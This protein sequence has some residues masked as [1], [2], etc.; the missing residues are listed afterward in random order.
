MADRSGLPRGWATLRTLLRRS[1]RKHMG[2]GDGDWQDGMEALHDALR[3]IYRIDKRM[4][5]K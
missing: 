3:L 4:A 5:R 2:D 1:L